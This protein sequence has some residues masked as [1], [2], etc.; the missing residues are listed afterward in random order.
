LFGTATWAFVRTYRE[1]R[2]ESTWWGW[3]GAGWFLLTLMMLTLTMGFPT[4]AF[5]G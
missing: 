4:L 1:W 5:G 2:N 3:Q